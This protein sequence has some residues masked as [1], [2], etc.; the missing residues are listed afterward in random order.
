MSSRKITDSIYSVGILNPIMRIFDVVMTTDYGTTYNSYIVKGSEKTALIDTCHLTYWKQYLENIEEVCDPASIDYI[1]LNHCEPD[2]SGVLAK[3]AKHCPNAE[4]VA[5]QAGS[6]YLKKITNLPDFKA[7]VAKDGDM[8]DLGDKKL[9]FISAP[10]LHWPDSM[11]TWCEE[12]KTLFSCDFLGCH[13]CEPHDFD[14]NIAYPEKYEDA[15]QYYYTGIF[16]PFPTYVQNGLNKIRDLDIEYVCNSHGPILTKGGRLEYTRKMY[17]EWSQPHKNAV[18]TVPI[19]YCSAYGNTGLVAKAIKAGIDEVI[20]DANVTVYDINNHNM[21]DLQAALNASDAFAIGTPTIN[22]DAVAPVWNLLSHVDAIN[23]KKK[24][25]LAF[26]SYGWSGE[27]VPN[28]I[29]RMQGLKLNV[30]GDG[31]RFQFVPSEAD[32]EKATELGREFAKTL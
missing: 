11:F 32:L 3:L 16:G 8:I 13:Y 12:E 30:F 1:I 22:A 23:N 26:G 20:P 25:A 17:N 29:A 9:K 2:H 31:F 28:I 19:F 21:S 18:K 15:F 5:S 24:P 4:I 6:I 14:Y 27:G 10:F 7:R